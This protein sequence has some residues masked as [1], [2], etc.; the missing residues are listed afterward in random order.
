MSGGLMDGIRLS[1]KIHL[2]ADL[3][4]PVLLTWHL[5]S[6]RTFQADKLL[7]PEEERA[8]RDMSRLTLL[9]CLL[10]DTAAVLHVS[11]IWMTVVRVL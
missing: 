1:N 11:E 8:D 4:L 2:A 7:T 3:C 9:F 5:V 10:L 6:A